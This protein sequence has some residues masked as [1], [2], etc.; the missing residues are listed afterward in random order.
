M[1]GLQLG[2]L[3]GHAPDYHSTAKA[4][5]GGLDQPPGSLRPEDHPTN[6]T[7]S[8]PDGHRRQPLDRRPRQRLRRRRQGRLHA[9]RAAAEERVVCSE[10]LK[11]PDCSRV[12]RE[13]FNGGPEACRREAPRCAHGGLASA[14]QHPHVLGSGI[15]LH[16]RQAR[17]RKGLSGRAPSRPAPWRRLA[18]RPQP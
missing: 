4:P 1:A 7:A 14:R 16:A 6:F 18:P 13:L 5:H 2:N 12:V 3:K 9:G 11:G 15:R 8:A 17:G 10:A